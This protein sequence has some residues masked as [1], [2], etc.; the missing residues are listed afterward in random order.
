MKASRLMRL[1]AV[2]AM[3]VGSSIVGA[4]V[5]VATSF[6]VNGA[7]SRQFVRTVREVLGSGRAAR[8]S[9]P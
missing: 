8:A 3:L 5:Y 2:L 9:R 4:I 6:V 7:R 1:V